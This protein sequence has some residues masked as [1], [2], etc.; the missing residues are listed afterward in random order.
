[1]D[2]IPA[3]LLR[4]AAL[5]SDGTVYLPSEPGQAEAPPPA[6]RL[7]DA[8]GGTIEFGHAR[9]FPVGPLIE[10]YMRELIAEK[11]G[12]D[13]AA[14]A[15][16][17][18]IAEDVARQ[19]R[20]SREQG[21]PYD[22]RTEQVMDRLRD[23]LSDH[24]VAGL[25]PDE[26]LLWFRRVYALV[27]QRDGRVIMRGERYEPIAPISVR[28]WW[29]S[30]RQRTC[31]AVRSRLRR[32]APALA[33]DL[34][35]LER[36]RALLAGA[37]GRL[38]TVFDAPPLRI[39]WD[40]HESM[41]SFTMA[42]PGFAQQDSSRHWYTFPCG[43]LSLLATAYQ[44]RQLVIEPHATRLRTRVEM[45]SA[46]GVLHPFVSEN[47]RE[48]C[49]AGNVEMVFHEEDLS[50]AAKIITALERGV[51]VLLNGEG[52]RTRANPY[53]SLAESG[54]PRTTKTAAQRAGLILVPW[55]NAQRGRRTVKL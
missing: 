25:V 15:F 20:R 39:T 3:V 50:P 51:H 24:S 40:T 30:V 29:D 37:R 52:A 13:G 36:F 6:F 31:R 42:F 8:P 44:L 5:L 47:N 55:V 38:V 23:Q 41:M 32:H 9:T 12:G 26:V 17:A 19:W 46:P 4:P 27:P 21:L 35:P 43:T 2:G 14:M 53:R 10:D 16:A 22:T 34:R 18:Q 33:P 45:P 11:A 54:A 1:M 7:V 48:L 49:S 28:R